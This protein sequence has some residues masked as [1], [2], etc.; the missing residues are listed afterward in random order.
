MSNP[1][2]P[3]QSLE[4]RRDQAIAALVPFLIQTPG[5]DA[6]AA[7]AAA[8]SVLDG[9]KAATPKALQLSAQIIVL[10]LTSLACLSAAMVAKGDSIKEMIRLQDAAL[11]FD[12]S[13]QKTTKALDAHRKEWAKNP[14]GMPQENARWD[15]GAFQL[16]INRA[17][18][19]FTESNNKVAAFTAALVPVEKPKAKFPFL[20]GEPM[21]PSVLAR[22]IWH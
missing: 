7:H 18:E 8:A 1:A 13:L 22:R 17:L 5:S 2:Q 9:Y 20:F 4:R 6:K 11:A 3:I 21:T 14:K 15:E 16:A 19:K 12:R 10:G